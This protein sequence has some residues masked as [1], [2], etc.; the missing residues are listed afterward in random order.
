MDRSGR[1][2]PV[3]AHKDNGDKQAHVGLEV[4]RKASWREWYW[5][6]RRRKHSKD[7]GE[8]QEQTW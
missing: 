2:S 4:A 5:R 6:A 7:K 3:G 1:L 8:W